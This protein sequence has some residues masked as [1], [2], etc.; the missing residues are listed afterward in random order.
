MSHR[1]K[2]PS[3]LKFLEGV[4]SSFL[5]SFELSHFLF[6]NEETP[7]ITI[8]KKGSALVPVA[9]CEGLLG[10]RHDSQLAPEP[11]SLLLVWPEGGVPTVPTLLTKEQ[12]NRDKRLVHGHTMFTVARPVSE[13][14]SLPSFVLDHFT[15]SLPLRSA[16]KGR[17]LPAQPSA[18]P[19]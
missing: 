6:L 3:T 19:P 4:V 18:G 14:S 16:P 10:R 2:V 13:P 5:L 15:M 12:S 9:L 8:P 17:S 1:P 7:G 11:T